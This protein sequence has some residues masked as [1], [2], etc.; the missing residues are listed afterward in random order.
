MSEQAVRGKRKNRK[1]KSKHRH[2]KES[3]KM[4]TLVILAHPN[5]AS[6]RI[7]KAWA[8]RVKKRRMCTFMIYTQ[9][10]PISKLM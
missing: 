4:K 8:E 6:S 1:E 3:I 10:I 5:L 7:N 2:Q 9:T